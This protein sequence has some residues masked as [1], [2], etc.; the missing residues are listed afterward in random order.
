MSSNTPIRLYAVAGIMAATLGITYYIQNGLLKQPEVKLP[1][2]T[3]KEMPRQGVKDG[4]DFGEW[5]GE[6]T[7][8]DPKL[9]GASGAEITVERRYSD[10]AGHQVEV[11]TAMFKNASEGVYHSPM[12]CYVAQGFR[13]K[14]STQKKPLRINDK[15]SIPV[16][17]LTW[18]RDNPHGGIEQV[19]VVYWYQ[20]GKHVLFGRTDL[21]LSVRWAL[22]GRPEWPA[23]TKVM[24]QISASDSD[25][26][27]H[28]ILDLAERVARWE[29]QPNH[30]R[31][32]GAD[33]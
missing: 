12:N 13:Q 27:E 24:M 3:F 5:R 4:V 23:L 33:D 31:E 17:V 11:Y 8:S 26:A 1:S 20:L 6:V 29:N 21:G 9:T 10:D 30:R 32:W 2:W 15:L 7:E 19:I 28:A 16:R 25:E 18:E 14:G 22:A